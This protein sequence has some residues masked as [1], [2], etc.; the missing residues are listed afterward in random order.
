M[1]HVFGLERGVHAYLELERGVKCTRYMSLGYRMM[2]LDWRGCA[3]V[4][5]GERMVYM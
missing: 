3:C 1:R 5:F 2:S 4:P